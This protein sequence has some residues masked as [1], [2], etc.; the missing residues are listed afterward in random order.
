M[1]KELGVW[2]H[3]DRAMSSRLP[4]IR[5]SFTRVGESP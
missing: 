3:E 2:T 1:N 5:A 4:T